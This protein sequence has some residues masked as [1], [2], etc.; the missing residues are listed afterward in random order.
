MFSPKLTAQIG[1]CNSASTSSTAAA[2]SSESQACD[3]LAKTFSEDEV[4][5]AGSQLPFLLNKEQGN[6][7]IVNN[8]ECA[9]HTIL[10][11]FYGANSMTLITSVVAGVLSFFY[12]I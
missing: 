8:P 1:V 6:A 2:L 3:A 9:K 12:M 7:N 11:T 4:L 10:F 5:K